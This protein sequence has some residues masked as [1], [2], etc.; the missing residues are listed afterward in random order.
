MEE[1]GMPEFL[2]RMTS[3]MLLQAGGC[4]VPGTQGKGVLGVY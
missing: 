1:R 2:Q 3:T 4:G